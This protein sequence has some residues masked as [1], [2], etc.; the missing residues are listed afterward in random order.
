MIIMKKLISFLLVACLVA[1][2]PLTAT[3]Q[4][5][6]ADEMNTVNLMENAY[7]VSADGTIKPVPLMDIGGGQELAP[8][9]YMVCSSATFYRDSRATFNASCQYGDVAKL[10]VYRSNIAGQMTYEVGSFTATQG[11]WYG[12][13]V[14]NIPQGTWYFTVANTGSHNIMVDSVTVNF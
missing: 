11:K 9:E 12:E 10:T 6:K 7:I 4:V 3:A 8:G 5:E 2:C 13:L 1:L 14:K